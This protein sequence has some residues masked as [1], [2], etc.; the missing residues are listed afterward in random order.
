QVGNNGQFVQSGGLLVVPAV[1]LSGNARLTLT[2]GRDKLLD[3]TSLSITGSAKLD[4]GDNRM[5]VRNG[6]VGTSN[7]TTYTGVQGLVAAGR[8][9]GSWSGVGIITSQSDAT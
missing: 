7:G 6:S 4:L 2:G 5:I 8:N 3:L 1:Q 9:G